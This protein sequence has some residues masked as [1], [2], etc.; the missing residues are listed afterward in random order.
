[1][2]ALSVRQPWASAIMS[3]VKRVE[4][5]SRSTTHRGTLAI[6]AAKRDDAP[7][8]PDD[9]PRGAVIG[10]VEVVACVRHEDSPAELRDDPYATGP[11]LWVLADPRPFPEPVSYRGMLG[12]FDVPDDLERFSDDVSRALG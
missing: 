12:L 8:L 2:K 10:T 11:W 5:R 7:G 1:M 9:L 4:N 6:H 3:G